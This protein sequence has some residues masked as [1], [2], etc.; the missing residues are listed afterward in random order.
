M[1]GCWTRNITDDSGVWVPLHP[2]FNFSPWPPSHD[3]QVTFKKDVET[4]VDAFCDLCNP[5]LEDSGDLT[6]DTKDIMDEEVVMSIRNISNTG[7]E[8]YTL[9]V[10]ERLYDQ[11]KNISDP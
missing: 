8:Q 1:D 7:R 6:L 3:S 9:F 4:L 11:K 2:L 5:F 10:Q